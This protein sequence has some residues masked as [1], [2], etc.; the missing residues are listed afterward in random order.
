MKSHDKDL[1]SKL[2]SLGSQLRS[3]PSIVGNGMSKIAESQ[4]PRHQRVFAFKSALAGP[5][6]GLAACLLIGVYLLLSVAGPASLTLADVQASIDSKPWVLIQYEDGMEQW[7]N[8]RDRHSFLKSQDADGGN[9]HVAMRDHVAGIS[10]HYHT[11][12][13]Q[14]IHEETFAPRPYP[15]TPWEYAVGD[16]DDWKANPIGHTSV[17]KITDTIEDRHVVRFDTYDVGPLGLRTLAQQV[18]ADPETRLP[19]RITKY[20]LRGSRIEM[21]TGNFTFPETGPQSIY[22]LG[23]PRDLPLVTNWGVIEPAAETIVEAAKKAWRQLPDRM[24]IVYAS[25]HG[26]SL[27]WR[28]GNCLRS[29]SYGKTD[30]SHNE[31]FPINLPK[32]VKDIRQWARDNLALYRTTIFD[33]QYEYAYV[34]GQAPWDHSRAP[35]GKLQVQRHNSDYIDVLIPI[36]DQWPYTSNVGPMTVLE[37]L[38]GVPAGCVLL[39]YEGL[40][41]R[42]DWYVDPNRDYICVRQSEYREASDGNLQTDDQWQ[43]ARTDLTQLPTGQWYAQTIDRPHRKGGGFVYDVTLLNDADVQQLTGENDA[44]GFF[45]GKRLLQNALDKEIPVTYWAR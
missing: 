38:P 43:I 5:G 19:L 15:Q 18:W 23:T 9:F 45:D 29:E 44:E 2:R 13:G 35:A 32:G 10:R 17:E 21:R 31:V 7:A 27:T 14:Q 26:L 12:W 30:V 22:D 20:L 3:Q 37:E 11:N 24:R 8:L 33:G 1:E 4:R 28:W 39:R 42:R 34:S 6:I 40:N 16:W 41:L 36:R 25:E